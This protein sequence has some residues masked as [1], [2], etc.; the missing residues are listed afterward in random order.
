MKNIFLWISAV[1][2]LAG[3]ATTP[4]PIAQAKQAPSDRLLA[5]QEKQ[6]NT[7]STLIVTRDTGLLGSACYYA[8]SINGVLAATLSAGESARFFLPPGEAL[9]QSGRD[10][11]GSG[12]CATEL[13]NV[14]QRETILRA[15]ETKHFRLSLGMDGKSDIQRDDQ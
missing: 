9:L 5:Y 13:K 12:L 4:T 7:T 6:L 8:V 14:T 1:L 11:K 3:C 10:P 15:N 2:L